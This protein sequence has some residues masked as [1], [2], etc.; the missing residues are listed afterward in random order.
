MTTED[1]VRTMLRRHADEVTPSADA[2]ER[3]EARID[4]QPALRHWP[5][6][7]AIAVSAA[8]V[9]AVL[10]WPEDRETRVVTPATT[11]TTV[12]T[13]RAQ[14]TRTVLIFLTDTEAECGVVR[15]V[16]RQVPDTK[17]VAIAALQELFSGHVTEQ[18]RGAGLHGFGPETAGLLRR[19]WVEDGIA[20]VDLNAS[21]REAIA[22][23]G[24]SCGGVVFGAMIGS[25]LR[26]FPTVKD[27]RYAFDGDPRAFV[28]FQQGYCP[29]DPIPPGDPC[30]PRPWGVRGG[31]IVAVWPAADAAG[32]AVLQE[33]ADRG[34]RPDLLDP[35]GVASGYL[36]ELAPRDESPVSFTLGEFAEGD[37]N[38][39]EVPYTVPGGKESHGVALLRRAGP[40]AIWTVVG[41][42]SDAIEILAAG[43][44]GDLLTVDVRTTEEG[45]LFTSDG[46]A[47]PVG[48][49]EVGTHGFEARTRV[50]SFK[51]RAY[52]GTTAFA[53]AMVANLPPS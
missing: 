42:T 25:T 52:D 26:Q 27:V 11:S 13:N 49:N 28:E 3:I 29:D 12:A 43:S 17:A 47:G 21:H 51:L 46:G 50:V 31:G 35:V 6:A 39:G 45:S 34:D 7:A 14:N 1:E 19:L 18:E 30:D 53:S 16:E 23:A 33:A 37:A 36:G 10:A 22:Q 2:W 38:S 44:D 8:L 40:E 48:A 4:D 5:I 24:T 41:L 9:V 20:Y 32:M 15:P